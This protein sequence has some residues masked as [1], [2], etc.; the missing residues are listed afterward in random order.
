[1]SHSLT[2]ERRVIYKP[3]GIKVEKARILYKQIGVSAPVGKGDMASEGEDGMNDHL[4][5]FTSSDGS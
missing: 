2:K 1:M 4:F 3:P 5:G